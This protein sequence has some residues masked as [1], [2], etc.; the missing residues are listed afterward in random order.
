MTRRKSPTAPTAREPGAGSAPKSGPGRRKNRG[1]PESN[2]KAGRSHAKAG[3]PNRGGKPHPGAIQLYGQ[4]AVLAALRNPRRTCRR[5]LVTAEA[6]RRLGARLDRALQGSAGSPAPAVVPA[7]RGEIAAALAPNAVHQGLLLSVEPLPQPSLAQWLDALPDTPKGQRDLVVVLDRVTDP[8]NVGAILR[9]AAAFGALAVVTTERNAAPESGV[10][11]KTASGAFECLAYI[12]ETN[13]ARA[14]KALRDRGF[15]TL[16]LAAEATR[17][18]DREDPGRRGALVM[19]AEGGGL[20]R[21]TREA[22]DSLVRLPTAPG[23]GQLNVSAAAAVALYA[24]SG[25]RR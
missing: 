13:L 17:T 23:F 4:H 1:K 15:W 6:R 10:L 5:L 9:A 21:L 14:L 3:R 22:C 19:G 20:R 7:E 24:L 18:I 25:A 8:Q 11:A 12:R 16:G 2:T